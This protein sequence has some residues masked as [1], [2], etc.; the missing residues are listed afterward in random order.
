MGP[1]IGTRVLRLEDPALLSGKGRFVDDIPA[2]GV[3]HVAFVRSPYAHAAIRTIDAKAAGQLPGVHAVLTLDDL[4]RVLV[5]RRMP[6]GFRSAK[7]PDGITPF[8]LANG[9]VAFVGDA[10]ALVVAESRYVAEDAAALV[11]VDYEVLPVVAD[12]RAA[13]TS[14]AP[15]VRRE[16]P[17]NVLVKFE[18]GYGD[19]DRAFK[20]AAFVFSEELWQHRGGAH[21]I[22]GR[23]LLAE[24]RPSDET[25]CVW[26]STQMPHALFQ[27][28]AELLD[29]D[30]NRFR[31]AAVDVGGGFGAKYCVYPEEIAVVAA[32]KLLSRSLKWVEDRREHFTSAIQERDQYWSIAVAVTADARICGVRGHLLHDQGAYTLQDVNLAYNS[33]TSVTGPYIVPAYALDVTVAQT[34]KVPVVP[35][36]GAGYPEACFAMERLLDRVA[37]RARARPRRRA[38]AKSYPG[39]ENA[40]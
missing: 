10:V 8:V 31:V 33:A 22:E 23:G 34:N 29:L 3:L 35:V 36:R 20:D 18:V 1:L 7:L 12:C 39:R 2:P 32:A 25:L 14:D 11:D 15:R 17:S 5:R 13:L 30:E 21:P 28:C 40:V 9:E 38:G 26:S 19:V 27:M 24:Y 6:L 37:L 4:A 16:A